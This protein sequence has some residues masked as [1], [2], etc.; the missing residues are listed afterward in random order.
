MNILSDTE[1]DISAVVEL[2]ANGSG[3]AHATETCYGLAC[4]LSNSDAVEKLFALKKRPTDMPVSALFSSVD[5]AK[6]YVEWNDRAEELAQKHLPGPLTIILPAKQEAPTPLYVMPASDTAQ[7][8]GVRISSHPVAQALVEQFGS[9][10]STTSANVHGQENPYSAEEIVNQY[11]QSDMQPN[12]ILDSGTLNTE[13]SS[14]IVDL[15]SEERLIRSGGLQ[16]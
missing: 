12:L 14:T 4:D 9:P 6:D 5:Q 8:I 2:L 1:E 15:S 11:E 7:T 16:I 13:A 3:S 10:I